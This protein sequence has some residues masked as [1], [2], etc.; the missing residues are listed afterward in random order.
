MPI[1]FIESLLMPLNDIT[2]LIQQV[3]YVSP[4]FMQLATLGRAEP[5]PQR[6]TLLWE[7]KLHAKVAC[8]RLNANN[9]LLGQHMFS[10]ICTRLKL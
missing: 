8:R 5:G 1:I 3:K 6:N 4:Q 10:N 9:L 7:V 2:F